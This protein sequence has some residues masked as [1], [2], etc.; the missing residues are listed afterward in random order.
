MPTINAHL[1]QSKS[2]YI[3]EILKVVN[4]RSIISFAGGLPSEE[5]FPVE[6]FSEV[7]SDLMKNQSIY[8][9]DCTEGN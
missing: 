2:S 3:R 4:D 8:Q 5:S 1:S 6:I 9:Y 7:S